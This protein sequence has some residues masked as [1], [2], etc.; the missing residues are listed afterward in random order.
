MLFR[1]NVVRIVYRTVNVTLDSIRTDM[2]S[3][4]AQFI[5]GP[6]KRFVVM[7]SQVFKNVV[8]PLRVRNITGTV[9]QCISWPCRSRFSF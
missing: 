7:R 3:T 8:L 6:V 9:S 1:L 5:R 4:A 2:Y